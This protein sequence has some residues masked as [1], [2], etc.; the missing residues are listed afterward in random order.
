MILVL[1]RGS[2]VRNQTVGMEASLKIYSYK[3]RVIRMRK[4]SPAPRS[5]QCSLL[6]F[7]IILPLIRECE[8]TEAYI[9]ATAHSGP[10]AAVE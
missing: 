9:A 1:I 5:K 7:Y 2:T 3:V 6:F 10:E 8:E 4:G